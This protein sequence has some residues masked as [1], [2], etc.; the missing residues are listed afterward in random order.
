MEL[1]SATVR[2]RGRLVEASM[3]IRN[4]GEWFIDVQGVAK[5]DVDRVLSHIL[6]L[7]WRSF[8]LLIGIF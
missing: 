3:I 5:R 4:Y 8:S 7:G 2:C 1:L 6:V